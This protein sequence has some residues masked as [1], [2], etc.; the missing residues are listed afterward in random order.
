M[1]A[2]N[3]IPVNQPLLDGNEGK[4]LSECIQSGW[5]SSEG[6]FVQQFENKFA[7]RIGR[8][9]AIAVSNGT[10][11]LDIAVDALEIGEKDEVILPTFT[12]ISCINQ[13]VRAGAQPVLVDA[14]P[15]TWNMD[16]EKIEALIT[17]RTK[18]IMVVHTY[19]MPV[20]MD[21]V[22]EIAQRYKIKVIE[23]AAEAHGQTYKN[24]PCGTLGD[25]STFSF[26]PNK[27]VTTGEGGMIVTD[28]DDVADIC[29]S[30]RNL[31]FQNHQRFIHERLGWNYRMTNIQAA[32]GLAQLE[33]MDRF[34][35]RK[36]QIGK[37]YDELLCGLRGVQLPI[38][39]TDY[40][41]NIYWVYGLVLNESLR[42]TAKEAMGG[43]AKLGVGTR[44]FFWP[45]HEQPVLKRMG[46]IRDTN[47]PV[48][49]RLARQGFYVPSGL[50][51]TDEAII[52][53]AEKLRQIIK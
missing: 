39:G 33:R 9:H 51:L 16:V 21:L 49:S 24:R 20:D 31:C 27:L 12:I 15:E 42:L 7:E 6:P 8:K 2:I 46:L 35:A 1:S 47:Y 19:G 18:A 28:D 44:P 53:C 37:M 22:L 40:A 25:I 11:A 17:P 43:L 52:Y 30:L 41:R 4:Y 45:I 13:I 5:I 36:I 34:V 29:R 10:A 50:A 14:H 26:Y 23:D 32:L 38:V 3:F 48:A